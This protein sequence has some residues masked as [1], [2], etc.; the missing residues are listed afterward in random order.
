MNYSKKS[1]TEKQLD[2]TFRP[3]RD[4]KTAL[5]G[6]QIQ[7]YTIPSWLG[8]KAKKWAKENIENFL[9]LGL[10]QNS[11]LTTFWLCANSFGEFLD[12]Q[13][14]LNTE[15]KKEVKDLNLILKISIQKQKSQTQFL[16][17]AKELGLTTR[18]RAVIKVEPKEEASEFDQWAK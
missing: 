4:S 2:G 10:L 15:N 3:D 6:G 16:N 9:T 7:E 13:Q 17:F 14:M 5:D 12:F 18:A 8:S 11:D 1:K